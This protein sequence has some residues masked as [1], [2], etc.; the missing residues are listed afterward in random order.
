ML[1]SGARLSV[2]GRR[3]EVYCREFIEE[4]SEETHGKYVEG[5][6]KGY[7]ECVEETEESYES[8]SD[9]ESRGVAVDRKAGGVREEGSEADVC[10]KV[11][12]AGG[13]DDYKGSRPEPPEAPECVWRYVESL[14][15][16]HDLLCCI[17]RGARRYDE[18]YEM[19]T[20]AMLMLYCLEMELMGGYEKIGRAMRYGMVLSSDDI[21]TV[22]GAGFISLCKEVEEL[23][24]SENSDKTSAGMFWLQGRVWDEIGKARRLRAELEGAVRRFLL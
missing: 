15:Y 2:D 4:S 17:R 24:I 10:Q 21:Y 5:A 12:E 14:I 22:K 3:G 9:S 16:S 20:K 8:F 13:E 7:H 18:L 6:T 19:A 23:L 11:K 1:L